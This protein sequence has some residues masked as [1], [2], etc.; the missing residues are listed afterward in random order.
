MAARAWI[1]ASLLALAAC[2]QR[3]GFE[4][5]PYRSAFADFEC[6]VPKG[7]AVETAEDRDAYRFTV[8]LG[9]DDDKALWGQA[10]FVVAWHAFGKPFKKASGE[11]GR[12]DS[13]DDYVG[14]LQRTV[15]S[16]EPQ[17]LEPRHPV[18]VDG[19][20]AERLVVRFEKDEYMSLPGAKPVGQGGGRMWRRDTAVIVPTRSGFYTLVFPSAEGVQPR[21]APAFEKLLES[22]RFLKE[23]PV[24]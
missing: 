11:A 2:R 13:P 23:S 14:Q 10:R 12:Y 20:P 8:L 22:F 16:P 21:Y 3:P 6:L 17:H 18:T 4:Y 9:P 24:E 7:W 19:R 1:A 15:W 5:T